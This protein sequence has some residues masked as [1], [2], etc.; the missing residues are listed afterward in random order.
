[1]NQCLLIPNVS[2]CATGW[3]T[4]IDIHF[5]AS[6]LW[7]V[8]NLLSYIASTYYML[9]LSLFRVQ[10]VYVYYHAM[11]LDECSSS[12]C[13]CVCEGYPLGLC[14]FSGWIFVYCPAADW[15]IY[16]YMFAYWKVTYRT[17]F[18]EQREFV[19]IGN[20]GN[21]S[22][23]VSSSEVSGCMIWPWQW[24]WLKPSTWTSDQLAGPPTEHAY[25]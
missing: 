18:F 12:S 7:D 3:V 17:L 10:N 6:S 8:M 14:F 19:G 22:R 5:H 1:M 11:F 23:S 13:R 2:I 9:Q 25:L 15:L 4:R 20:C 16:F 21:I 24:N